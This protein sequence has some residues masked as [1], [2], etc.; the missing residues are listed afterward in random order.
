MSKELIAALIG[1]SFAL[2]GITINQ[3]L[4]HI[5]WKENLKEKEKMHT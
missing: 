2:L 1:G 3:V 4:E 5:R